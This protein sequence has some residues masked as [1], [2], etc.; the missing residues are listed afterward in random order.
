MFFFFDDFVC[1]DEMK[2]S[3]VDLVNKENVKKKENL[4]EFCM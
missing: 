1:S 4:I 2:R 3:E